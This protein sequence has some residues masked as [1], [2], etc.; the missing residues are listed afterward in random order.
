MET[1]V[2][3]AM[4][5]ESIKRMGHSLIAFSRL[6]SLLKMSKQQLADMPKEV[7][8]G[9]AAHEIAL[10]WDKLPN[11]LQEDVDILKYQYCLEHYPADDSTE[12]SPGGSDVNDGP[13]PRKLFCCYCKVRDVNVASNNEVNTAPKTA[14]DVPSPPK[15]RRLQLYC[16]KQ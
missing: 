5:R 16:C 12:S 3:P 8:I 15:K 6:R 13:V 4:D 2:T 7:M 9:C 10:V 11:H 14:S 1:A